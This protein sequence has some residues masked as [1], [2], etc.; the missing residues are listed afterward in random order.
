MDIETQRACSAGGVSGV[1]SDYAVSAPPNGPAAG[2]R[3]VPWDN[4][5]T[6]LESQDFLDFVDLRFLEPG[7]IPAASTNLQRIKTVNAVSC[8]RRRSRVRI[9]KAVL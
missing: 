1:V 2:R 5:G 9:W 6:S 4:R 7:A 3:R 8:D